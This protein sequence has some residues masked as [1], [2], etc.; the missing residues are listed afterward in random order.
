MRRNIG[1][2][3][4]D[5]NAVFTKE[6]VKGAEL[7]AIAADVNMYIFPG[8]FLDHDTVSNDHMQYEY[9]YEC[10]FQ[11]AN[12]KKLDILYIMMGM[13]GS[14][15]EEEQRYEFLK[16]FAGIPV[17]MMYTDMEG[18]PSIIFDNQIAFMDGIR[19]LIVDKG[20]RKIG[21]VSGPKQNVDAM[22][23]LDAY[24]KVLKEHKIPYNE[25]YVIYGNF[26]ESSE[27]LIGAFVA[28]HPELD[29]V[30]FAND[31]MA[32]GG[33]EAFK[34]LG[35]K[36]GQDLLVI[37]FDNSPFAAT[38]QPPLT[39]V[40]ANAAELAYAAIVNVESFLSKDANLKRVR[41]QNSHLIH[42]SSCGCV[43]I[44]HSDMIN[45]LH[46]YDIMTPGKWFEVLDHINHYL[47]GIYLNNSESQQI[48]DDLSVF[49]R[50]L[51]DMTTAEDIS[52][53]KHDLLV[54]FRQFMDQGLFSYTSAELFI[55][56]LIALQNVLKDHIDDPQNKLQLVECFSDFFLNLSMY[57]YQSAMSQVHGMV[58]VSRVINHMSLAMSQ[59]MR[60][61]ELPYV[62]TLKK[63][64]TLGIRSSYLYTFIRPVNRPRNTK[65]KK[66]D[67]ILFRAYA[68]GYNLTAIPRRDQYIET[69][70][71]F[72]E[73]KRPDKRASFMVMPLFSQE[74]IYGV[75]VC[76]APYECFCNIPSVAIHISSTLK[77]LF[78]LERQKEI[79]E[80]LQ[81]NLE[82]MSINNLRLKEISKTDQLTGLFNRWGFLD[83]VKS[84]TDNPL[85]TNR[86]IM[87]LYADMDN[88]KTINDEYGHD[89]GDF[90]LKEIASI[91]REAFRNTDVVCRYGGDEFVAFAMIG[92]PNY[93]NI[94]KLRIAE[95]T[96]R[97]NQAAQKPYRIEMST[98]ICETV[99][100]PDL[101]ID[102]ILEEADRKLYE[103]KKNKKESEMRKKSQK[104]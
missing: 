54:V 59:S 31:R 96:E 17:V 2:L 43:D 29:A 68:K 58:Q 87:V 61:E 39:T 84:I 15:V 103:E 75:L 69:S 76:E 36:V 56:L 20:C 104:Q 11:F 25:N 95:I 1:L 88:L 37:S 44:N 64:H 7:G 81:E 89:D 82:E 98:G 73:D 57:N 55:Q 12:D 27:D 102:K 65:F 23:R 18:Y 79:N 13:I 60:Q 8:M 70:E 3:I 83:Y 42:R 21:Y 24:Q 52:E 53:R 101:D 10:I 50:M 35:I 85:N 33:Y 48:M 78:L 71:M 6:A 46:L 49:L 80:H 94:M 34:K 86:K 66:P 100:T 92:I 40:E 30:V 38:L 51:C 74:E 72:A 41:R 22:E 26:E 32:R 67:Y 97:H 9:Q 4:D 62:D 19:H 91:L 63:L 47:F 90:A 93:S 14:R 99:C 16:Q 5:V 77:T 28:T 45:K